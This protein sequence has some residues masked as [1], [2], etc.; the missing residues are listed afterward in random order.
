MITIFF[1]FT[2][3]ETYLQ[4][5]IFLIFAEKKNSFKSQFTVARTRIFF[6]CCKHF[7]EILYSGI[8][9]YIY[10]TIAPHVSQ[11]RKY[12]ISCWKKIIQKQNL[13]WPELEFSF[14]AANIFE[15]FY[16]VVYIDSPKSFFQSF[17][18]LYFSAND[19]HDVLIAFFQHNLFFQDTVVYKYIYFISA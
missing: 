3:P 12:Q 19:F 14:I 18:F 8:H 9:I 11:Q 10:P 7:W 16:T 13:L 6:H 4:I 15:K 2:P 1:S 5:Q 17:F